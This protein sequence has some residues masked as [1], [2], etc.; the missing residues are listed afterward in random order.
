MDQFKELMGGGTAQAGLP[1]TLFRVGISPCVLEDNERG[2]NRHHPLAGGAVVFIHIQDCLKEDFQIAVV[3]PGFGGQVCA[4]EAPDLIQSEG[5]QLLA[6]HGAE[7]V[8]RLCLFP[9]QIILCAFSLTDFIRHGHACNGHIQGQNRIKALSKSNLHRSA[10]LPRVRA[11]RH[12]SAEGSHVIEQLAGFPPSSV[13]RLSGLGGVLHLRFLPGPR[14][15]AVQVRG[16][17]NNNLHT[18]QWKAVLLPVCRTD[19]VADSPL[20]SHITDVPQHRLG[21]HPGRVAHVRVPVGI[22][23]CAGDVI[24][25][26]IPFLD[27]HVCPPYPLTPVMPESSS[28]VI[29]VSLPCERAAFSCFLALASIRSL[30]SIAPIW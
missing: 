18:G 4:D 27:C 30:V 8:L 9:F 5:N 19:I 20:S 26:L 13:D 25:K 16:L 7:F 2:H 11:G 1:G 6:S 23:V 15:V 14:N 10:Y 28:I 29:C 22:A 24:E 21:V 17:L 12:H 3:E